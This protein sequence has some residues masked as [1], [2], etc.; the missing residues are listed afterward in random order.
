[1][2]PHQAKSLLPPQEEY[3][4]LIHHDATIWSVAFSP[5]D[6][7]IITQSGDG[8]TCVWDAT[9]GEQIS[10]Q[11]HNHA[12]GCHVSAPIV[13]R[14]DGWIIDTMTRRLLSHLPE[15]IYDA[16]V[17]SIASSETLLALGTEMGLFVMRFPSNVRSV[18]P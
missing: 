5:D 1:V 17:L 18:P 14:S 6:E 13:L 3:E 12:V 2:T 8:T 16:S 11:E 10:L 9:T 7:Q 15:D 4:A